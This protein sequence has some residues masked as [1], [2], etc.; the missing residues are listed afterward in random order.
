[1]RVVSMICLGLVCSAAC[2]SRASTMVNTPAQDPFVHEQGIGPDSARTEEV[3]KIGAKN[4][5]DSL[6]EQ[7]WVGPDSPSDKASGARFGEVLYDETNSS[8]SGKAVLAPGVPEGLSASYAGPYVQSW[9]T[10]L[11]QDGS[12]ASPDG[13][14]GTLE[15]MDLGVG[16]PGGSAGG[17]FG[18]AGLVKIL[19]A[20]LAAVGLVVL[21][22]ILGRTS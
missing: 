7:N 8:Q 5:S 18:G 17:G 6:I 11:L 22:M 15:R 16:V 9:P 10:D 19:G 2:V 14:W 12:Q 1:M 3:A 21:V 13:L 4:S 20:G